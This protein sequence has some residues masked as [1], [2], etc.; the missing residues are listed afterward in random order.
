[1]EILDMYKKEWLSIDPNAKKI[2]WK[3]AIFHKVIIDGKIA[4]VRRL[5]KDKDGIL[6]TYRIYILPEFRAKAK[7]IMETSISYYLSQGRYRIYAPTQ[8]VQDLLETKPKFRFEKS[9]NF[10]EVTD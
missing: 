8:R 9:E 2:I 10:W 4:A 5:G 3:N 7:L 1:M 6:T